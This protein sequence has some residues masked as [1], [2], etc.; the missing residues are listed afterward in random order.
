MA[1]KVDLHKG[2]PVIAMRCPRCHHRSDFSVVGVQQPATGVIRLLL[3]CEHT[4]YH[5]QRHLRD[6]HDGVT[7][8]GY[9]LAFSGVIS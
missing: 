1:I 5:T 6:S 8:C 7:R 3:A 2:L 4:Y 9:I